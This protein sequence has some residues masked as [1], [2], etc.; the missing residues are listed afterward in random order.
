VVTE[1]VGCAPDLIVPGDTGAVVPVGDEAA[2]ARAVTDLRARAQAGHDFAPAC[3]ARVAAFTFARATEGLLAAVTRLRLRADLRAGNAFGAP[4]V[5]AL[6]GNMVMAG[7]LE[8]MTFQVLRVLRASGAS[9]HVIVNRWESAPIVAL[10]EQAG[11]SWSTGAY[12]AV[13]TRRPTLA[14]AAH[15]VWDTA[16]TSA[17][18]LRDAWRQRS[19]VVLVPE[20]AAVLR[21]WPGLL[22]LRLAGLGVVMRLGNAPDQGR[23]HRWMWRWVIG[24]VV[25]RFVGNSAFI[26]RE[27][28]ACGIPEHRVQVVHNAAQVRPRPGRPVAP[29]PGRVIF[30]GQIIPPKGLH[31][32]LDAIALL[33]ARGVEATLQVVGRMDGWVSPVYAGYRER[34]QARAAQADLQGHVTFLGFRE[35]VVDLMADAWVH[36]CPSLP[37][38]REGL[39]G[40]VLEA[41]QAGVPSVVTN[42]GSLP[43]LVEHAVDGW[44]TRDA[45]SEAVA[46]GLEVFLRDA[47]RRQQAASAASASCARFS[48]A[49]FANGWRAVFGMP[50]ART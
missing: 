29:V 47:D 24:A 25:Q 1:R 14:G 21:N 12:M 19:T 31:V 40:V 46:D 18:L 6:C 3:R 20:H 4:R 5:I 17:G 7:G 38:Q 37:E 43:E 23:F 41:K 44:V 34:L 9:V 35:D 26:A 27:V 49:R 45:S 10:A 13:L 16:A 50:A 30:V 36:C 28:V 15:L 22:V 11:A 48:P 2:L 39:A 32:L 8:R 33:R 42:T